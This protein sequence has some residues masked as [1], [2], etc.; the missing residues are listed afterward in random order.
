MNTRWI[1]RVLRRV[2]ALERHAV[3]NQPALVGV[4]EV[5]S[6]KSDWFQD[7]GSMP[8]CSAGEGVG[9]NIS[10]PLTWSGVPP[11]TVELA[12]IL[13][14]ADAP[15]PRPFVHLIAYRIAPDR[16]CFTEGALGREAR[17]MAFGK[18][19]AGAQGYMGPRPI[20]G[21][22]PH[23]Y[24]WNILALN[25]ATGFSSAPKLKTFLEALSGKVIGYGRLVGIYERQ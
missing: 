10:P 9:E 11:K 13:E 12:I 4:P 21:H 7:G 1:G 23:R 14:D 3:R 6:L 18:S 22:G 2:R 25:Q 20:L 17:G 5:I 24:V 15:L 19:T 16:S 8:L